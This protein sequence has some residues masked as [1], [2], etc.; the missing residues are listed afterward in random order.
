MH[1]WVAGAGNLVSFV[2]IALSPVMS[3]R[4]I[5]NIPEDAGTGA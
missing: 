5:P 1:L 4:T 3:L 2:W